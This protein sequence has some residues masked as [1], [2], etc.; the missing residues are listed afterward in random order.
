MAI[1][2]FQEIKLTGI[3]IS[4]VAEIDSAVKVQLQKVDFT[5]VIVCLKEEKITEPLTTAAIIKTTAILKEAYSPTEIFQQAAV[6]EQQKIAIDILQKETIGTL[7]VQDYKPEILVKYKTIRCFA[8]EISEAGLSKLKTN[9]DV[10]SISSDIKFKLQLDKS[11]LLIKAPEVWKSQVNNEKITGKDIGVCVIDS[12]IDY[13]HEALGSCFGENCKIVGG[14]DFVN[15]DADPIDDYGHG[16]HIAGIISSSNNFYKGIAPEAKLI[17]IKACNMQGDCEAS[18]V[19]AGIDWCIE[20]AQHYGISLIVLSL[21]DSKA[22]N[23]ENCPKTIKPAIEE[24]LQNNLL[25]LVASGNDKSMQGISYPACDKDVVAVGSTDENLQITETTNRFKTA[26]N[27]IVAP[28]SWITST[29]LNNKFNA[30]GGTST[31]APHV[32]G[33]AAL[34]IQ[35]YKEVYGAVPTPQFIQKALIEN[36][37]KSYDFI[38]KAP[39]PVADAQTTV[40]FVL[41]NIDSDSDGIPDFQD[42]CPNEAG[43]AEYHGCKMPE[44][45][46]LEEEPEQIYCGNNVCDENETQENCCVDCGCSEGQCIDNECIVQKPACQKNADCTDK[47]KC[48]IDICLYPNITKAKCI[49]EQI[50]ECKNND[51]CCPTACNYLD[52]NDCPIYKTKE[53]EKK[54][55]LVFLIVAII[56]IMIIIMALQFKKK[57]MLVPFPKNI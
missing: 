12:G 23:Y 5:P 29:W 15:N 19:V 36:G 49:H 27:F 14:Y 51:K 35:A 30:M 43:I 56:I 52:D 42:S 22:Y 13:K 34:F 4:Q 57:K 44:L 39:Y 45:E 37:N 28:G 33:T 24:A 53:K 16:T 46:E 50:T 3:T 47:D 6:L 2:L 9:P 21:G 11:A 20:H 31:A 26:T 10:E 41:Q 1:A 25:I 32:A 54:N 40:N 8:T 7:T 48:T 17:A 18:K 38:T 55:S